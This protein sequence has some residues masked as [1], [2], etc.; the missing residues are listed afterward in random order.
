MILF[1][2]VNKIPTYKLNLMDDPM[3]KSNDDK[4]KH[5][6]NKNK[7]PEAFSL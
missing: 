5:C 6:E 4:I 1:E 3:I 7:N 2:C